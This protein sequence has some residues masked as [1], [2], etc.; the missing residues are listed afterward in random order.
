[1]KISTALKGLGIICLILVALGFVL[2]FQIKD[3]KSTNRT[4]QIVSDTIVSVL[5]DTTKAKIDTLNMKMRE[6]QQLI[7]YSK[8]RLYGERI[9]TSLMKQNSSALEKVVE[10]QDDKLIPKS[11]QI[12]T[13]V[14]KYPDTLTIKIVKSERR[15]LFR[16]NKE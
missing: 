16:R 3:K 5:P 11:L 13:N 12:T 10:G 9:E 8:N 6:Y 2:A 14:I 15:G 1:M 4:E 7:D